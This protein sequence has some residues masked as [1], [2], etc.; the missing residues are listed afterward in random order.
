MEGLSPLQKLQLADRNSQ[1]QSI[2]NIKDVPKDV[3]MAIDR[4]KYIDTK[5]GAR[6]AAIVKKDLIYLPK[7]YASVFTSQ[8]QINEELARKQY[9]MT[10]T[11]C[12]INSDHF[13]LKFREEK[14]VSYDT[15][16]SWRPSRD[17]E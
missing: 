13:E 12:A 1:P 3:E 14:I 4:F 16:D 8:E 6:I 7:A 10:K 2:K 15:P 9:Y 11:G 17:I 5:Y